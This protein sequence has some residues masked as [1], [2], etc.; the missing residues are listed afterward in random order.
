MFL[1]RLTHRSN[2]K[3]RRYWAL[4]ESYRTARGPRH[5][6]LSYL[7]ELNASEREGWAKLVDQFDAAPRFHQHE[8]FECASPH[9]DP[10]PPQLLVDLRRVRVERVREFGVLWLGLVLWQKLGL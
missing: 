9:A 8:L 7:G 2:G 3:S 4:V 5:R 1:K 6:V 10:V